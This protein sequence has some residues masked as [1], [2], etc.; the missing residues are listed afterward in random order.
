MEETATTLT[1]L[2]GLLLL[3]LVTDGLGR[4]A[5]LPGVT[6]LLTLGFLL[7]PS[8]LGFL[9]SEHKGWFPLVS[10]MALLMVGFLL[11]EKFTWAS[12]RRHGRLVLW[13]SLAVVTATALMVTGGLIFLGF[14]IQL[15]LLLGGIST[16]TDPA[17]TTEVAHELA[18]RGEFTD[19]L[20]GIVA[21]DDVWGL[22]AFSV[23]L[24]VADIFTG[25]GYGAQPLLAGIWEIGGALLLGTAL[26]IPMAYLTGRLR[27]GEPTLLE[28]VGGVF[29]C[30][31]LALRLE[32]SF[33]LAAMVQGIVVANLAHHHKRPFHAIEG[34]ERPFMILFFALAGA[35]FQPASLRHIGTLGLGYVIFRLLGRLAGG[36]AGA[37]PGH[38]NP[39]IRHWMGAAL[40]PQA[41][42]A[43]GMTLL[44][45]N[46]HPDLSETLLPVVI[47]STVIF[48]LAGPV[49]TRLALLRS[50][51]RVRA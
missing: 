26:G 6:L 29:L 49:L 27:P 20:L 10:D 32:V 48:E 23:L 18:A 8:G 51:D 19:T 34:I 7:G 42:V 24:T 21:L 1:T 41:G 46:R 9:S 22:L 5:R 25:Q 16:A 31:G 40:L 33:L 35:S 11:G 17:A 28:A 45:V 13:I 47:G 14:P 50:G 36:W 37:F 2:G 38:A 4:R 15:A 12:L 39:A 3:G 43:L 44:A 30:G